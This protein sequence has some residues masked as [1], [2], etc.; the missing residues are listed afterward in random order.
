MMLRFIFEKLHTIG[1]LYEFAFMLS[2]VFC[3]NVLW[4]SVVL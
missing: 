2:L 1:E 3:E 4:D